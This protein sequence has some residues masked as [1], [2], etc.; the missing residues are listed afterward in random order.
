MKFKDSADNHGSA[1]EDFSNK[2]E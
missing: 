1:S 2:K